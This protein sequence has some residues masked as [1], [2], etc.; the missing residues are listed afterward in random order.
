MSLNEYIFTCETLVKTMLF[1][2]FILL[3]FL[4]AKLRYIVLS[5]HIKM[6]EP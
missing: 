5:T 4:F 6:T 3:D 2:I 1:L